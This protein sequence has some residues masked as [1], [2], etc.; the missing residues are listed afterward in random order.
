[1]DALRAI[2][3]ELD[4]HIAEQADDVREAQ[5]R[6]RQARDRQGKIEATVAAL[7]AAIDAEA[8]GPT[9]PTPTPTPTPTPSPT[10]TPTPTPT[11]VPDPV[12]EPPVGAGE[13]S[14]DTGTWKVSVLDGGYRIGG[15]SFIT[16]AP[17]GDGEIDIEKRTFDGVG[18]TILPGSIKCAGK[19]LVDATPE[20][21]LKAIADHR[22]I[23]YSLR[24]FDGWPKAP[25]IKAEPEVAYRPDWTYGRSGM[26]NSVAYALTGAGG[27]Y[28]SSRGL[29]AADDCQLVMGAVD[30]NDAQFA[31]AAE[32]CYS[33]M[34]YGL[35]LPN[36]AI[37]S[38]THHCLRDPQTPFAGE[39]PYV[40][41]GNLAGF[42]N[43]S[44]EGKLTFP[45][46]ADPDMLAALGAS[47]GT[48]YSHKR[49]QAH[50]F[51]HNYA[52]WLASGDPRAAI[53]QQAIAAYALA[54]AYQGAYPDGR[55]RTR[56]GYGRTTINMW[57]AAWKLRDVALHASGDL[58]W[59]RERS[60]RHANGIIADWKAKHAE[61]EAATDIDSRS[62][63][64]A[65]WVDK[66]SGDNAVSNFMMV[67][68]APEVS[69]LWAK[70]GEPAMMQLVA[71]H[72]VL[73][74]GKIGGTRGFYGK[75]SGSGFG[76][77]DAGTMPYDDEAG[78]IHWTN[79][80]NSLPNDTFDGAPYHYVFRS[81]WAL[82]LAK[83]AG[84][85]VPGLDEAIAAM[86]DARDRTT[87]WVSTAQISV[88][89]A[90]MPFGGVA[91]NA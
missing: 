88:K 12:P 62:S 68:Y 65:R 33:D 79:D 53:L 26:N 21:L 71:E 9:D 29:L 36:L 59:D 84:V 15:E 27:D 80:G 24:A 30:G 73:R 82:R 31:A 50:L 64:I 61:M 75:S 44:N 57:T 55:T 63:S 67:G 43:Y 17:D 16:R 14:T 25:T 20:R 13:I 58:L 87:K 56:F 23:P 89:H 46:D 48:A 7:K 86:E 78:F 45:A 81:Y 4:H 41:E 3:A 32:D 60:L 35:S 5:L 91:L 54:S 85:I 83:A 90:G 38:A 18:F 77:L 52:Y 19:P 28:G 49:D 76:I 34:L 69:Y 6:S 42:D 72:F 51:N 8:P 11:P 2:V 10:P 66:N 1:M 37:W 40:N 22:I 70:A 47:P 39:N 74:F